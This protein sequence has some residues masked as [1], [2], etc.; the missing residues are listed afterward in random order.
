MSFTRS[1]TLSPFQLSYRVAIS[2]VSVRVSLFSTA[3]GTGTDPHQMP[4]PE[5]VVPDQ[6]AAPYPV[7]FDLSIVCGFGRGSSE[8]GIPTANVNLNDGLNQLDVGIYYG[9]CRLTKVDHPESQVKRDDGN[10]V[11]FNYGNDLAADEVDQALPMV[12]SIGYNPYYN[13]QEKTAE[14]HIIHKF[15][16]NFY[17]A[18]IQG[19]VLGYIRPELDYTTKEALI[20]DINTDIT[21]AQEVLAR[22]PYLEYRTS[23]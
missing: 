16:H 23:V 18:R 2:K 17:G 7:A 19:L 22:E 3:S 5:T 1:T 13:N 15:P 8:L 9:W 20:K 4:R 12:M 11:S 10:T 14:V 6:V 21:I